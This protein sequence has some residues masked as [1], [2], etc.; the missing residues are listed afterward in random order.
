[1]NQGKSG[2]FE[3]DD[4]WQPCLRMRA[5]NEVDRVPLATEDDV[6]LTIL[7]VCDIYVQVLRDITDNKLT[8]R[9]HAVLVLETFEE[10]R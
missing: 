6:L 4:K 8:S 1:M 7:F 2:N 3:V 9:N 10:T 5:R